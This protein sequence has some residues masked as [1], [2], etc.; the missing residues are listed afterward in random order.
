M[1]DELIRDGLDT[2]DES[3]A[4]QH[5]IYFSKLRAV[6]YLIRRIAEIEGNGDSAG[7][8]HSKIYRQP[9]EAVVH[10]DGDLV[11]AADSARDEQIGEPVRFLVKYLPRDLT[12]VRIVRLRLNEVKFLPC[13]PAA[14]LLVR[15]QLHEGNLVR[16][17]LRVALQKF[18]DWHIF[19]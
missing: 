10:Q 19:S 11:S 9:F 5:D 15:I 12:A 18:C 1:I 14:V 7:L 4:E 6:Q 17:K 8:E 3:G 2:A 16:I 13:H